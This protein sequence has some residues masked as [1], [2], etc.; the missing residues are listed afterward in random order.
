M[1]ETLQFIKICKIHTLRVG[2]FFFKIIL[3]N[4]K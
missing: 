4:G 3:Y 1:I 2:G